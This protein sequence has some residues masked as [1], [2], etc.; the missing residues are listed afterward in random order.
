ME[1]AH[2][3]P[4]GSYRF[5]EGVELCACVVNLFDE[6]C[7]VSYGTNTPGTSVYGGMRLRF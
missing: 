2:G 4:L 1:R 3:D 6:F 7:R 5:S